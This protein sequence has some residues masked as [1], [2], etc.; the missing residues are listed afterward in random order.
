MLQKMIDTD[1]RSAGAIEAC[2]LPRILVL[3]GAGVAVDGPTNNFEALPHFL[4]GL[5]VCEHFREFV[6]H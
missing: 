6:H 4:C 2:Y 3:S 1:K 5:E